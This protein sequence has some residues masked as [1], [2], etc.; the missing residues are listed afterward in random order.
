MFLGEYHEVVGR[1]KQVILID[2]LL[3]LI[4]TFDKEIEIPDTAISYDTL[5]DLVDKKIG[6]LNYGDGN[7][8]V[9]KIKEK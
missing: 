7:Y 8:V 1:L 2:N 5:K 4:F 3:K 9:R 6:V